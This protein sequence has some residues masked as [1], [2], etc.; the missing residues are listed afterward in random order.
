M[1]QKET[2]STQPGAAVPLVS[3]S[4]STVTEPQ[5]TSSD[6][7]MRM[8]LIRLSDAAARIRDE[9]ALI[10]QIG[11]QDQTSRLLRILGEAVEEQKS[12]LGDRK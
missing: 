10:Q 9:K 7:E 4:N 12:A 11:Y 6:I 5:S 1:K 8:L 3:E 2:E